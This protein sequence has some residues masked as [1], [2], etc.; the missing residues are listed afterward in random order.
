M[1]KKVAF[2]ILAIMSCVWCNAQTVNA[3]LNNVTAEFKK[4]KNISADFTVTSAHGNTKGSIVMSGVKFRIL[5]DD[6]KCWYNGKD[7]WIYTIAT[8]EVN[9]IEPDTETLEASNP[10]LAVMSYGS[11]YLAKMKSKTEYYYIVELYA[12]NKNVEHKKIQLTINKNTNRISTAVVTLSDNST[13]TIRL[14]N[15]RV[16]ENIPASTFVFDG[17]LVPS[18]TPVIDLR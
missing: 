14:S 11:N 12:K 17:K 16:N 15:Y 18:G 9:L 2:L 4:A 6:I 5:S 13:Q 3:V 10:Y 8:G 1:K 7:E